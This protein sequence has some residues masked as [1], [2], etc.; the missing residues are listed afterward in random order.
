VLTAG[1][2]GLTAA[3]A[4]LLV[5]GVLGMSVSA[6]SRGEVLGEASPGVPAAAAASAALAATG[7]L[8]LLVLVA[9]RP[10]RFFSWITGLTTA[11]LVLLPFG[12][13]A[14]TA[15]KVGTA[16]VHLAVGVTIGSLLSA[17]GRGALRRGR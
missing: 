11:G 6:P 16:T 12:T 9:P 14:S 3:V 10:G 13:A 17:V 8:H 5:R 7:L 2:A 4:V 15:D 1:V